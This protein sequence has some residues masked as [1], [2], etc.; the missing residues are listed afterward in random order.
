MALS[1]KI[2]FSDEQAMLQDV[3]VN[4]CREKVSIG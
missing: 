3:A 4:F 2:T 1:T